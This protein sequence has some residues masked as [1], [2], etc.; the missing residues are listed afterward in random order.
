LLIESPLLK[1]CKQINSLIAW[2][3]MAIA[4]TVRSPVDSFIQGAATRVRLQRLRNIPVG[5]HRQ[6]AD[7]P[8]RVDAALQKLKEA[9]C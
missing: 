8:A 6:Q 3:T 5:M 4:A 1:S 2:E 9:P 7:C